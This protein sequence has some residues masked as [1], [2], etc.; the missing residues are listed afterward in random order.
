[1]FSA[2]FYNPLYNAL[3]FLID[4]IPGGNVGLA[5][6]L[7]TCIVRLVLFPLSKS[8]TKTQILMKQAEPELKKIREQYKNNRE[9]LARKTLDFYKQ[10][11]LNPFASFFL[12]LLQ[13]PIILALAYIFYRGG[14]PQIHSEILYSF[15]NPPTIINMIFLGSIDIAKTSL[16][17][18]ILTGLTQFIQIRLSVPPQPFR[19]LFF[20]SITDSYYSC[21][22]IYFLQRGVA[23]NPFRNLIF[24]CKPTHHY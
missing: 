12:V 8:A 2:L 16:V 22:R 13:I 10:N 11:N 14:L 3:I 18:S 24:L 23:S 9:E 5:T 7:L 15:V 6:I 21:T 20:G 19:K 1:M 4:V 17:L